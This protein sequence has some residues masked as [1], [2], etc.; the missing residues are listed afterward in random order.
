MSYAMN[1]A[2]EPG[3][4]TGVSVSMKTEGV[5]SEMIRTSVTVGA[6]SM[7]SSCS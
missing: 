7:G 1:L 5:S 3:M 2:E 6:S 4:V